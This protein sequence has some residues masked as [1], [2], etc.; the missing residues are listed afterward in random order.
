MEHRRNTEKNQKVIRVSSVAKF[1]VLSVA[2]CFFSREQQ[3]EWWQSLEV[4]ITALVSMVLLVVT[5]PWILLTKRD[6]TSAVAWCLLVFFVPIMGS[7]FFVLFG[8][9]HIHRRLKKKRKHKKLFGLTHAS[10]VSSQESG[11]SGQESGS[12]GEE[13]AEGRL[14]PDTYPL[15]PVLSALAR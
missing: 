15:T 11:V 3:M 14:T 1:S 6:S 4:E 10:G 5:I 12:R 13:K 9:Q 2:S 8:Y 7:L